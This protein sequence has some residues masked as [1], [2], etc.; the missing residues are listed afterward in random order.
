LECWWNLDQLTQHQLK[1]TQAK[2]KRRKTG[3]SKGSY[4]DLLDKGK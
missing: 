1:V 2:R 4:V 3:V